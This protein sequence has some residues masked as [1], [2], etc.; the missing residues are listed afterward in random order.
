MATEVLRK[1]G[2]ITSP[3][4]IFLAKLL[5]WK[6]WWVRSYVNSPSPRCEGT[7]NVGGISCWVGL[8]NGVLVNTARRLRYIL[9]NKLPFQKAP[10]F[11]AQT[12][13]GPSEVPFP[14][15][16]GELRIS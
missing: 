6:A 13:R 2:H 5:V 7:D 10:L 15:P 3:D 14:S 11:P 1:Y 16:N 12:E 9:S 8:L 4:F